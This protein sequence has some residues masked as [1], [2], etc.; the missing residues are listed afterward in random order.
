MKHLPLQ[1][2]P[3]DYQWSIGR[4]VKQFA[5]ANVLETLDVYRTLASGMVE[6]YTEVDGN[7][8]SIIAPVTLTGEAYYYEDAWA[9]ELSIDDRQHTHIVLYDGN[10]ILSSRQVYDGV[11]YIEDLYKQVF[12]S[13]E[14]KQTLCDALGYQK[15]TSVA[16]ANTDAG[17]VLELRIR[18]FPTVFTTAK[19]V[20][21]IVKETSELLEFGGKF[22]ERGEFTQYLL[23]LTWRKRWVLC[24]RT[25]DS[26]EPLPVEGV[27]NETVRVFDYNEEDQVITHMLES[28]FDPLDEALD[29]MN[30]A[31]AQELLKQE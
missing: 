26:R 6:M 3:N 7:K 12:S 14:N 27:V 22:L 21:V 29:E 5:T 23:L 16:D 15:Q 20:H 17:E 11:E 2:Q 28:G 25:S 18:F 13:D 8:L 10:E 19:P 9:G 31:I 1:L 24:I 30:E 4:I